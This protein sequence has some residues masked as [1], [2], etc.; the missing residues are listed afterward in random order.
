MNLDTNTFRDCL[1][2]TFTLR[3]QSFVNLNSKQSLTSFIGTQCRLYSC[4]YTNSKAKN[5]VTAF[6]ALEETGKEILTLFRTHSNLVLHQ[7]LV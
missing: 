5:A 2:F 1:E 4:P 3:E 6:L 7:R